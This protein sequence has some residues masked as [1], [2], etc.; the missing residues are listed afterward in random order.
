MRF[1]VQTRIFRNNVLPPSLEHHLL[2]KV[3]INQATRRH[4]TYG[5]RTDMKIFAQLLF[6]SATQSATPKLTPDSRAF[7]FITKGN[8]V[9]LLQKLRLVNL[10]FTMTFQIQISNTHSQSY[11]YWR[12]IEKPAAW[13]LWKWKRTITSDLTAA[14]G[15]RV[16]FCKHNLWLR[17][18]VLLLKQA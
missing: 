2:R 3:C 11:G 17:V 1:C 12:R 18:Q 5:C 10:C 4:L 14:T 15:T 6:M 8:H 16:L 7:T 13:C 9:Q